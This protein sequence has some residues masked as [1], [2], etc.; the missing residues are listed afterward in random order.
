MELELLLG[1]LLT[2]LPV[3]ELRVGLPLVLDYVLKNSFPIWPF[4][5]L[6]ILL[7]ILVIFVIFFFLDFL[8]EKLMSIEFYKKSVAPILGIMHRKA[9]RFEKKFESMDFW[10][11]LLLVAIPLPGTG[12]WTGVFIAWILGLDRKKSIFSIGAGVVIAGIIVLVGSLGLL[13]YIY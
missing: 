5:I 1:L 13:S 2:I 6:V 12:A 10:A 7:N 11:L 3:T 9:K 4:F 8:H